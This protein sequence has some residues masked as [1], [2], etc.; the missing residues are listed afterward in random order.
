MIE[1]IPRAKAESLSQYIP[2]LMN[3]IMTVSDSAEFV[4]ITSDGI[5]STEFNV[6]IIEDGRILY[7]S[8]ESSRRQIEEFLTQK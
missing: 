5:L 1:F 3:R 7:V 4:Q 6:A 8:D 2:G